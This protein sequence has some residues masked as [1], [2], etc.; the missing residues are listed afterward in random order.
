MSKKKS[1]R[2]SSASSGKRGRR[3]TGSQ[4]LFIPI[5]VGVVVVALIVG[6][7]VSLENRRSTASALPG[8]GSSPGSA[9][10]AQPLASQSVPFPGVPRITLEETQERLEQGQALLVDV[11]STGSYDKAHAAGA[12]SIPETEIDSRL[13]ELPRDVDLVLY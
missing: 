3:S 12:I 1:R 9:A 5:I 10:S 8:S 4:S 11:R 13:D 6:V 7:V 2:Q